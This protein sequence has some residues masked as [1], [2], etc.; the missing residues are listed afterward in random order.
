MVIVEFCFSYLTLKTL[1]ISYFW[2]KEKRT[3]RS[4]SQW[5]SSEPQL[6]T[7]PTSQIPGCL[8]W[9]ILLGHSSLFG[10]GDA[11]LVQ[12][13]NSDA[14]LFF[15]KLFVWRT[16]LSPKWTAGSLM[17][18]FSQGRAKPSLWRD[19]SDQNPRF[20]EKKSLN[21]TIK[22]YIYQRDYTSTDKNKSKVGV[23]LSQQKFNM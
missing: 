5:A 11:S 17:R 19:G 3:S 12:E 4:L 21:H 8:V 16:S 7:F 14:V 20:Y 9:R 18:A 6:H 10:C 13:S 15:F 22:L 23:W 2:S 1:C